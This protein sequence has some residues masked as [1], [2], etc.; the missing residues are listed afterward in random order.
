MALNSKQIE[1][2]SSAIHPSHFPSIYCDFVTGQSIK[3]AT[4]N[5]VEDAIRKLLLSSSTQDVKHGLANI[6]YWGYADVVY[7][8]QRVSHFLERVNDDVIH[9]FQ[10]LLQ[11]QD[12]LNLILLRNIHLPD[13]SGMSSLSKIL[14]FLNPQDYCVL[15]APLAQLKAVP[16]RALHQLTFQTGRQVAVTQNNQDTYDQWR[17]ECAAISQKYFAGKYRAV[18]IERGFSYLIQNEASETAKEIYAGF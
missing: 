9:V 11:T 1:Q 16:N 10:H 8:D 4:V 17:A 14:T 2:F 6:I 3:A 12:T 18:E 5:E 7:R 15:D 13:Y